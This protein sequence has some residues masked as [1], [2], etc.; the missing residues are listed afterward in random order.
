[1]SIPA[2]IQ[3]LD[4]RWACFIVIY[5]AMALNLTK[6]LP[7]HLEEK[8]AVHHMIG[9]DASDRNGSYHSEDT[10]KTFTKW[11]NRYDRLPWRTQP[12]LLVHSSN[13]ITTDHKLLSQ[14]DESDTSGSEMELI[15]NQALV[16]FESRHDIRRKGLGVSCWQ[17]YT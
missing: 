14:L 15:S 9:R 11:K 2:H 12:Q 16:Q 4:Q 10:A 8:K 13:A 17:S 1:M 7:R 6:W 5:K 3:R